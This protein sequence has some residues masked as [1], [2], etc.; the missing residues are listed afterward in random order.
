MKEPKSITLA[1]L[2]QFKSASITPAT[3]A[4]KSI[5]T[6]DAPTYG[7]YGNYRT[8]HFELTEPSHGVDRATE[9]L[10]RSVL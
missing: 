2:N 3:S 9:L 1:S 10:D 4:E 6:A 5:L 8:P 7:I